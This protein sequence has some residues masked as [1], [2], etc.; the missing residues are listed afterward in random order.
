MADDTVYVGEYLFEKY[1][2][3]AGVGWAVPYVC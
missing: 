1:V 2:Y 3:S